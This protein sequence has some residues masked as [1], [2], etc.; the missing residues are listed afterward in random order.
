MSS[1]LFRPLDH[2]L[3]LSAAVQALFSH[4]NADVAHRPQ[5]KRTKTLPALYLLKQ[6]WVSLDD[7]N[8]QSVC[9]RKDVQWR[10]RSG[11]KRTFWN[12]KCQRW[13]CA[14]CRYFDLTENMP[15]VCLLI[16]ARYGFHHLSSTAQTVCWYDTGALQLFSSGVKRL[17]HSHLYESSWM[18][19]SAY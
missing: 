18:W 19:Y 10:L 13:P 14:S 11:K 1:T 3:L 16:F 4:A 9:E 15:M 7:V 8:T 5:K 2:T 17:H 12:N 6:I